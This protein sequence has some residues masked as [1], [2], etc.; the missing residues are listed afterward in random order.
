MEVPVYLFTGFLEAG[1]T[2]FI[3]ETLAAGTLKNGGRILLLVCE[4][5]IEEFDPS[6]FGETD[7]VMEV[8]E[9]EEDISEA[10]LQSLLRKHRANL[11]VIE[12]NGMWQLSSL[13]DNLPE[14]WFVYQEM[15]LADSTTIEN[16]NKNMR[17]L[18]VDKLSSC[19]LAAFNRVG[20]DTDRMALHKLVRG[21]SRNASIV[22]DTVDG[23]I[24]QDDIEDP[25]PFDIN[26]PV[27]TIGDRDYAWWYRDLVEEQEKYEGKTVTFK[28]VVVKDDQ[29]P[30]GCFIC[31][32]HVMTC[33]ADDIRY[34]GIACVWKK[35]ET[36][37]TYDW[38]QITGTIRIEAHEVYAEPGPVIHIET[39]APA[40]KPEEEVAVFN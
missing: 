39:A 8:I 4:E 15:F 6:D 20:P 18:V 23:T 27:V 33:C 21:V 31:G 17:S 26:A 2:C 13:Y 7:C 30:H 38:V 28:G 1:K 34:S 25:L 40:E 37:K 14:D 3:Q 22:Y 32:R 29:I 19:D 12:Y 24:E 16:Y 9:D 10:L 35:S 36:L 5:G 11:V